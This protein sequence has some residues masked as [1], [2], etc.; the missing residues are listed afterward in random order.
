[1]IILTVGFIW[2]YLMYMIIVSVPDME[3]EDIGGA[4]MISMVIVSFLSLLVAALVLAN[5]R[6]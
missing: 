6:L 1:M 2:V 3:D 4:K 5:G